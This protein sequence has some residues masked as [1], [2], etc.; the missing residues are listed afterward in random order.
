LIELS[1][2]GQSYAQIGKTFAISR[3]SVYR[4]LRGHIEAKKE[5]E[6]SCENN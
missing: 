6:T 1:K 3:M 5:S 2:L 4:H